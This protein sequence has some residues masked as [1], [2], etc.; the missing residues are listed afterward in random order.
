MSQSANVFRSPVARWGMPAMTAAIIVAIAFL[1][2]EDQ[3]L[4]LAMVGVAVADF[5]VTPQILKRAAQSA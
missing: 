2:I 5:L 4:R 1:V 3:T